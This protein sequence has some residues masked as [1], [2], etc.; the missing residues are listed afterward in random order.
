[1]IDLLAQATQQF[2]RCCLEKPR[3]RVAWLTGPPFSGKSVLARQLSETLHWSYLDYTLTPGYFDV[4]ATSITTYQPA[5]LSQA[6]REQ[7]TACQEPVLIVD[8]LDA[9]LA[10]WS[11]SQ[12]QVWASQVS[13]LPYLPCGL[14]LVTHFFDRSAL[15][16]YL[17]D[18]DLSYCLD[19]FGDSQ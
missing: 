6:L 15:R 14:I 3:Y 5:Q 16:R 11:F 8:E 10:T 1:M 19:L 12:R 9:L 17:P 4:L 18:E 2:T 13:R 7:C